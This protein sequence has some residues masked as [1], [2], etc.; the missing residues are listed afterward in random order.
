MRLRIT[1]LDSLVIS[2]QE[3]GT[4]PVPDAGV[5]TSSSSFN[6]REPKR[7]Q[8]DPLFLD[9]VE[10]DI[11]WSCDRQFHRRIPPRSNDDYN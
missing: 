6:P 3:V 1:R 4:G 2:R 5:S 9:D 7:H 11:D 8:P 10:A